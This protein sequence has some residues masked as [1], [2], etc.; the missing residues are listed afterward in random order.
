[1]STPE[2]SGTWIEDAEVEVEAAE[3]GD[4]PAEGATSDQVR[5]AGSTTQAEGDR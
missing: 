3:A 1:M 5:N 4:Q 2:Q